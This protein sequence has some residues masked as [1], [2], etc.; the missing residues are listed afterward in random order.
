MFSSLLIVSCGQ[1]L[2]HGVLPTFLHLVATS[3]WGLTKKHF[4]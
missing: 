4:S 3:R 2:P 1:K